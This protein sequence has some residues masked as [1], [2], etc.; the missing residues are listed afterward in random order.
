LIMTQMCM[1]H[2]TRHYID[3]LQEMLLSLM[4]QIY[5]GIREPKIIKI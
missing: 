4:R 2:V 3:I 5:Q 1:L